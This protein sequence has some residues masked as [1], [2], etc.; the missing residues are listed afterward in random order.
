MPR[1]VDDLLKAGV[2]FGGGTLSPPEKPKDRN[3]A[4]VANDTVIEGA[5]ALVGGVRAVG[6]FIAPGNFVSQGIGRFIEEGEASQ[7][8]LVQAEKQQFRQAIEESDGIGGELAAVGRY[9]VRNPL[10]TAAQAIGSFAVP[11]AAIRGQ[12]CRARAQA[13]RPWNR[14]GRDRW[15]GC[16]RGSARR[17]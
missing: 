11:G 13:R 17:W 8:D 5:N 4:A 9:V 3:L 15:R 16:R 7:S 14:G 6:D 12:P 1:T 10:L 2:S